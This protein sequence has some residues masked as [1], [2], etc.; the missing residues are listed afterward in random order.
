[1]AK[2]IYLVAEVDVKTDSIIESTMRAFSSRNKQIQYVNELKENFGQKSG[3]RCIFTKA[4]AI[5]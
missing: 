2:A 4:L 3:M 1:M 5:L